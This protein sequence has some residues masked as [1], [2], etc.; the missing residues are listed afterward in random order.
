[1]IQFLLTQIATLKKAVSAQDTKIASAVPSKVILGTSGTSITISVPS[2]CRAF[3][4][5]TSATTGRSF[6]GVLMATS[7]GAVDILEAAKGDE[8][9]FNKTVSNKLTISTTTTGTMNILVFAVTK[10]LIDGIEKV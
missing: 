2:G 5:G 7:Q 9:V 8:I 10:E 1:M 6:A 4:V 3:I